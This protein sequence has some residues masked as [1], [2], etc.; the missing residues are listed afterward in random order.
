MRRKQRRTPRRPSLLAPQERFSSNH[1]PVHKPRDIGPRRLNALVRSP[2]RNVGSSDGVDDLKEILPEG[3]R[4]V[5][6]RINRDKLGS[7]DARVAGR[8]RRFVGFPELRLGIDVN[9]RLRNSK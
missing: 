5:R 6:N 9:G 3:R 7:A 1:R 4:F 8:I 2:G